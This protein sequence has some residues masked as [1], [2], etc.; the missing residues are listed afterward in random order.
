MSKKNKVF[1]FGLFRLDVRERRLTQGGHSVPLRGR[2]FD[3]LHVLVSNHGCLV[4]KDELMAAVWPDSVVEETN[5]NHN[6]CILRRALGEKATGQK[7]IETVPRQGYRFVA[8]VRELERP[9]EPTTTHHWEPFHDRPP[10]GGTGPSPTAPQPESD[11]LSQMPGR[12]QKSVPPSHQRSFRYPALIALLLGAGLLAIVYIGVQRFRHSGRSFSSRTMLAVLPFEN[13]TE[14]PGGNHIGDGFNHEIIA[15]L[16][17]WNPPRLGVIARTSS[18]AYRGTRKSIDEIG[19]ELGVNYIVEGSVRR[20]NDHVRI[21]IVLV[22]VGDQAQLWA[23]NYDGSMENL[24]DL[25]VEVTRD[26]VR[27]IGKRIAVEPALTSRGSD[28]PNPGSYQE[29][30]RTFMLYSP[31]GK[32]DLQGKSA[33]HRLM[34][35]IFLRQMSCPI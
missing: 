32:T 29:V 33:D 16:G 24:L 1:E 35:P 8:Q 12:E 19:R 2:V 3:T 22:R 7:Y 4:T 10:S 27:E 17:G 14:N 34:I 21:T 23:A 26:I 25:Q 31:D 6:I 13:L 15:Q 11:L 30:L 18:N 20:N 5:L 9:D 28:W